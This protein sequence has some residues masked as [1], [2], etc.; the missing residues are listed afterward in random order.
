MNKTWAV[1]VLAGLIITFL[2]AFLS[3]YGYKP[4]DSCVS[5]PDALAMTMRQGGL[6]APYFRSICYERQIPFYFDKNLHL[7]GL[8][9]VAD[10][11]FWTAIS[12]GS[13]S[14]YKKFNKSGRKR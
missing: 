12:W 8:V 7:D 13:I 3:I 14:V 2:T 9:F 11:V 4:V 10:A 6:P 5:A 1:S